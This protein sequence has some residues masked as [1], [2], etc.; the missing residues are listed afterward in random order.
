MGPV[1]QSSLSIRIFPPR[2]LENEERPFRLVSVVIG[3]A[4]CVGM[5]WGAGGF[6]YGFHFP[7]CFKPM[8]YGFISVVQKRK[9]TRNISWLKKTTWF[10]REQHELFVLKQFK[11]RDMYSDQMWSLHADIDFWCFDLLGH[12]LEAVVV[13]TASWVST[14]LIPH[15]LIDF[16][17]G[18][19]IHTNFKDMYMHLRNA[20]YFVE[21]LG[22]P[23]TCFDASKYSKYILSFTI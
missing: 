7:S 9:R 17:N 14:C 22:A 2:Q 21:V 12:V 18:D 11:N 13:F 6:V 20:G 1:S 23:F 19:H 10:A 5:S 16:R 8:L 15:G 4:W 3:R